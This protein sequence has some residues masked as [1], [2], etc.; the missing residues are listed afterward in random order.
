MQTRKKLADTLGFSPAVLQKLADG[1]NNYAKFTIE[2]DGKPRD[3]QAPKA[4]L[5]KIHR[6]LFTF[7]VRIDKPDYLHSGRKKHSYISNARVHQGAIPLVKL[8]IKKFYRSIDGGRVYRFFRES[9]KCSPDVAGQLRKLCTVDEHLPTGSCLSQ[10][11]A[12]FSAKQMFDELHEY[13]V[14]N[15]VRG[16]CYV[17]DLTWSGK[18]A[19]ANFLWGT[20]KIVHSHGFAY[21]KDHV[22][23]EHQRKVVTGVFISGNDLQVIPSREREVWQSLNALGGVNEGERLKAITSL[24][25]KV[26]AFSQIDARYLAKV[27]SLR[28][29]QKAM[30]AQGFV[31]AQ[32]RPACLIGRSKYNQHQT[33]QAK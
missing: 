3:I 9:L 13:A 17:D 22:Y 4:T 8:D 7:L 25:G 20:K 33:G 19:T 18:N 21:H 28:Q 31:T 32:T 30:K 12:F 15:E 11:L 16:T 1:T 6:K 24:L 2:Q 27:K 29:R 14:A 26:S 5:E 10:L 23:T